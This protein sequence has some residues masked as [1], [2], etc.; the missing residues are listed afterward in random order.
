MSSFY[1]IIFLPLGFLFCLQTNLKP[2]AAADFHP[3][4]WAKDLRNWRILKRRRISIQTDNL[5]QLN[6][7]FRASGILWYKQL[8][9]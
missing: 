1:F 2:L 4:L 8:L 5:F 3:R 9:V 6:F 7:F